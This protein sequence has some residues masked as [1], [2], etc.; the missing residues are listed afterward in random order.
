MPR[1]VLLRICNVV[2]ILFQQLEF[3]II[4]LFDTD[5]ISMGQGRPL[6]SRSK[7]TTVFIMKT[8]RNSLQRRNVRV[9]RER[10][11]EE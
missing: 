11:V 10:L 7:K 2:L 3:L 8:G 9:N 6:H 1:V 5:H 4:L